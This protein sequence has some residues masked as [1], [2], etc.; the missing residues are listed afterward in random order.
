MMSV[1]YTEANPNYQGIELTVNLTDQ[2]DQQ[3]VT[4]PLSRKRA[5]QVSGNELDIDPS[6]I[7]EGEWIQYEFKG[8]KY[9]LHKPK[10]GTIEIYKVK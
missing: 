6:A 2:M 1:V 5:V 8:K 4:I 7:S 3:I 10:E 9:V